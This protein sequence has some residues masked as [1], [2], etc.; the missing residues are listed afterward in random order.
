MAAELLVDRRG[1]ALVLTI[2]NPGFRN[3][4][5]P[6]AY[7]GCMQA[8]DDVATDASI[9][10]V[11]LTGADG[12]FCAGG[13]L[14]RL[15]ENRSQPPQVQADSID[16]EPS[17]VGTKRN[18]TFFPSVPAVRRSKP[19]TPTLPPLVSVWTP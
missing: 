8:F 11:V 13:N 15:L 9:R 10:A 5:G 6:E 19:P 12:M 14:N 7:A 4:L 18:E 3:A 16:R 17:Y 1:S 2:S